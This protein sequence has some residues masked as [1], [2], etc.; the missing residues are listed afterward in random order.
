MKTWLYAAIASLVLL[1]G[2]GGG[3][4]VQDNPSQAPSLS[5][6]DTTMTE[7]LWEH[8]IKFDVPIQIN[9][10]VKAY[11]V[12]FSTKRKEV[13]QRQLVRSTRYL[14]MIK[15][16]FQEYGLPEDLAYLAMI[17]SGFNPEAQSPA[18]ARGMWQ[19]IKGTGVR[20]GL[21]IDGRIDERRDPVKSTRAAARYLLD[22]YQ[23]FGSWY[24]A[25]ASYNCGE[26]RVQKELNKGNHENFWELSADKRLPSETQNYVPQMIAATI[27][28]KNPEKFG[29]KDVPY[30][31]PDTNLAVA[32]L[33]DETVAGGSGN[34]DWA[35]RPVHSPTIKAASYSPSKSQPYY[36]VASVT[37]KP[38][39]NS[40]NKIKLAKKQIPQAKSYN[41]N[42]RNAANGNS[43]PY[44]ASIF[45]SISFP[46]K[47]I[48]RK[49]KSN[50]QTITKNRKTNDRKVVDRKSKKQSHALFALKREPKNG[51]AKTLKRNSSPVASNTARIVRTK[52]K[53]FQVSEAR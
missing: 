1:V 48:A 11:L 17:E 42:S 13:I 15:E 47:D 49:N 9:K 16:V 52:P 25:A 18:G 34:Q 31:Q 41:A 43:T 8:Q 10:Q 5:D 6:D 40:D 44:A 2:C 46:K 21:V 33:T 39:Q 27:I 30:Q 19:F 24:L 20:Y 45:G 23:Q 50:M 14:P 53:P 26:R 29:F 4:L 28:A 51:K 35:P 32:S 37:R 36:A 7:E 12:Y 22:L 38:N 3:R